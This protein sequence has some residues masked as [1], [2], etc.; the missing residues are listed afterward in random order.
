[1]NSRTSKPLAFISPEGILGFHFRQA[2][3]VAACAAGV[4]GCSVDGKDRGP[5]ATPDV[6]PVVALKTAEQDLFHDYVADVQAVRNVE[7]RAQVAGFLERIYVDE[8]RPVKKGQ[9]LFQLNASAYRNQLSQAQAALA[10]AQAQAGA[11]DVERERVQLLAAKNI[12]AKTELTLAANKVK[13]ARA[14][15]AQ[16]QAGVAAARLSLD[17]TLVRAPFDGIID[18]IPLKMGSLV[19]EGT[20]LTTV[21]DLHEVYAYFNVGEGEYLQYLKA[22][23]QYPDRH[24]DSVR[25]TLADNSLYPQAGHIETTES[26]FNPNTGSL[27]FRARFANPQGLLKHG[28]SGRIRLTT[29]L[30]AALLLPQKAVFEIQDKNYVY[31]VDQANTV[32]M[33]NFVPQT[34]TGDFYVVK[35]GL[36]PGERI[37]Y[38]GANSLKNGQQIKPRSVSLDS[39]LAA[40]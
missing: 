19:E 35:E 2:L 25:L 9:P 8:G 39:L 29:T 36:K 3:L 13:D 28:A 11:A 7:V 31:V 37:V 5:V 21:S 17:Y 24:S 1:M 20:L 30:P 4:S 15:V 22:R 32:H 38:E 33:R 12:V 26:E 14:R 16:A 40:R 18:R 23:Q 10:S 27:A 34:R 6:R